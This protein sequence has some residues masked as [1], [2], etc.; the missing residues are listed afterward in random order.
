MAQGA[1]LQQ[2]TESRLHR[3]QASF[4]K[5]EREYQEYREKIRSTSESELQMQILSLQSELQNV[6]EDKLKLQH[7]RIKQKEVISKLERQLNWAQSM[8][9][10]EHNITSSG[11]NYSVQA[12]QLNTM[13]QTGLKNLQ[14][15]QAELSKLREQIMQLKKARDGAPSSEKGSEG[16]DGSSA[17]LQD[18]DAKES[19]KEEASLQA[20]KQKMEERQRLEEEMKALLASGM[21][22]NTDP[23]IMTLQQR[24]QLLA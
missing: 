17:E 22:S 24:I 18:V 5:L 15:D 2:T 4:D 20:S 12:Q 19:V 9:H 21:Y 7:A 6:K 10:Q 23:I 14:E 13:A 3:I 16:A 11:S 8:I 1:D